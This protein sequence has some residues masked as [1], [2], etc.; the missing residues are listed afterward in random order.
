MIA[1]PNG[2]VTVCRDTGVD[3]YGDEVDI[4]DFQEATGVPIRITEQTRRVTTY[5]QA[6]PRVVRWLAGR[7]AAGTDIRADDRLVH[8]QTGITYLVDAVATPAT[9]Q[10]PSDLLLDLRQPT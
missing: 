4:S 10:H 3:E 1:T 7:V 6:T 9:G 2:T 8:E 5:D